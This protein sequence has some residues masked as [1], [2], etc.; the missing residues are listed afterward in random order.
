MATEHCAQKGYPIEKLA[1]QYA[2]SNP[3]IPTTLFS[4]ANPDN[5]KRN[6]AYVEEPI[7]WQ[8]VREVQD[9]IG[10]AMRLTWGNT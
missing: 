8:L 10:P 1:M 3:R 4:S 9:I 6:L 7:D 2:V 5:V